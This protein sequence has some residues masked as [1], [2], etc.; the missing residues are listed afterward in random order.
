MN[1]QS[2]QLFRSALARSAY[3]ALGF[4]ALTALAPHASAQFTVTTSKA[5]Y[6]AREALIIG[7][8][9][10]NTTMV[11]VP[12]STS[13]D[14]GGATI[15]YQVHSVDPENNAVTPPAFAVERGSRIVWVRWIYFHGVGSGFSGSIGPGRSSTLGGTLGFGVPFN[16]QHAP[17]LASGARIEL[18]TD[19][20]QT[21]V[22]A[23]GERIAILTPGAYLLTALMNHVE[24]NGHVYSHSTSGF[25]A[26]ETFFTIEPKKH[27]IPFGPPPMQ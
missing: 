10:V 2:L 4:T 20:N 15:R 1:T 16:L 7:E 22:L 13:V 27:V 5:S 9:F 26:A 21:L 12:Y 17:P 3:V 19:T 24:I 6:E 18:V 14:E 8:K 11:S 25:L 23:P